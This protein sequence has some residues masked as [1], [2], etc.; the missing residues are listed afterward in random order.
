MKGY[1]D[2]YIKQAYRLTQNQKFL[3][4][5]DLIKLLDYIGFFFWKENIMVMAAIN[6]IIQTEVNMTTGIHLIT[7]NS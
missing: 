7:Q 1:S 2:E 5:R 4:G 3:P 6:L